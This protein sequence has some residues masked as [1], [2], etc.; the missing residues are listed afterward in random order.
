M[1]HSSQTQCINS[2]EVFGA[3]IVVAAGVAAEEIASTEGTP[4]CGDA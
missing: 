2:P 1:T 3:G 4:T